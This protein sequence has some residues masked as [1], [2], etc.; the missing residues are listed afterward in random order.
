MDV[1]KSVFQLHWVEA[2]TGEII[3]K[4]VKRAVFLEQ[5]AKCTPCLTG[6]EACGGTT[7]GAASNGDGTPS[8]VDA[9]EMRQSVCERQQ[10]RCGECVC[11]LAG[12]TAARQ[13]SG[14]EGRGATP[15]ATATGENSHDA[16]RLSARTIDQVRQSDG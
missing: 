4:Q 5:F 13:G 8:K 14:R 2:E 10:E 6:M 3:S 11:R 15:D 16:G 9:G 7:L 1:A 12:G